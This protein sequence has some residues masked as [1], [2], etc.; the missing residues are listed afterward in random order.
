MLTHHR[1]TENELQEICSWK[2]DGEY[3]LYNTVSF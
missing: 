3:A 2:Y 1:A